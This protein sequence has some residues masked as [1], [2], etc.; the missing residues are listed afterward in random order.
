MLTPGKCSL[1]WSYKSASFKFPYPPRLQ[2]PQSRRC[3]ALCEK[4]EKCDLRTA[5]H[6]SPSASSSEHELAS[7]HQPTSKY[8]SPKDTSLNIRRCCTTVSTY[9]HGPSSSS[10]SADISAAYHPTTNGQKHH[11][12]EHWSP[13]PR[14]NYEHKY[15]YKNAPTYSVFQQPNITI[16]RL[17]YQIVILSINIITRAE[18]A[19]S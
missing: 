17:V 9:S 8:T 19:E 11:K 14:R 4:F 15:S 7:N 2:T 5:S 13:K 12:R 6:Y 1:N 10:T 18:G 3:Q 16:T